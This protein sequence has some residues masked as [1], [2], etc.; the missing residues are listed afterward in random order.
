MKLPAGYTRQG[1]PF[2]SNVVC[3]LQK[4]LY[5]L[6]QA[7]RQWFSKFSAAILDLGFRQS[8]SDHSLFIK[9][10]NGLFIALLVYVDDV[11]IASNN[12]EAIHKLK[13]ELNSCFKL[14]DLGDVMYFLGLEIARS[15][16]GICISQRKHVLDLLSNFDYL[17]CKLASTPMEANLKLSMDE[18][19]DI[20]DASMYRRLLGKLL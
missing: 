10:G 6:K 2:P 20:S 12:Q 4:S 16:A 14:K 18:G 15:S 19:Y 1:V 3:L 17:G 7:S 13:S 8:P 11:I 5:G 9:I